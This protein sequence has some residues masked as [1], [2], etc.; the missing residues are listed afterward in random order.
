MMSNA[1]TP[2]REA[3]LTVYE[4][5]CQARNT[6]PNPKFTALVRKFEDEEAN[7]MKALNQKMRDLSSTVGND[8]RG[9]CFNV[10]WNKLGK[11]EKEKP[12]KWNQNQ[13]QFNS[14]R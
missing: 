13:N 2:G 3:K 11:D 10:D 14:N 8:K 1:Q 9:R 6:T 4:Q 12:E 7:R 5:A